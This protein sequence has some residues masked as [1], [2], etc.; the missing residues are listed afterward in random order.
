MIEDMTIRNLSPATQQ[1]CVHAVAK[2]V[3]FL[4]RSPGRA[5]TAR[6]ARAFLITLSRCHCRRTHQNSI[7]SRTSGL[8]LRSN[9]LCHRMFDGYEAIIKACA[10]AWNALMTL[11]D[12]IRSNANT[13]AQD[14]I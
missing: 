8:F 9:R 7:L 3:R 12:T 2:F 1:S 4:G 10:D 13:W 6:R 5:G 11:P 14:R